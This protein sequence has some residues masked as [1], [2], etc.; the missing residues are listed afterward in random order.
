MAKE[1][2]AVVKSVRTRLKMSQ[3]ELARELGVSFATVNRWENSRT[4]PSQLAQ[5]QFES[6]CETLRNGGGGW[7]EDVYSDWGPVKGPVGGPTRRPG[8][9]TQLTMFSALRKSLVGG[10]L[11]LVSGAELFCTEPHDL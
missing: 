4:K 8:Q 2:S 9:P 11:A 5:R 7:D 1:F 10:R 3:E 6:F